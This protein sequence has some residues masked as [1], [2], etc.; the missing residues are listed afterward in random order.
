MSI[1]YWSRYVRTRTGKARSKAEHKK[2]KEQGRAQ[3]RKGAKQR[4]G[5]EQNRAQKRK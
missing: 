1:H 4:K 5:K 3:E 2:G